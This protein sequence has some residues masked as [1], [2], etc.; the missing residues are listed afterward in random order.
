MLSST[1]PQQ[2]SFLSLCYALLRTASEVQGEITGWRKKWWKEHYLDVQLTFSTR[3]KQ[4]LWNQTDKKELKEK[5]MEY[6]L[7]YHE[8]IEKVQ[9]VHPIAFCIFFSLHS[10]TYST[11]E[12]D[13]KSLKRNQTIENRICCYDAKSSRETSEKE[14][15]K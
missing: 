7:F 10:L 6:H 15:K 11:T 4:H 5:P 1:D 2:Q 13:Y 14:W 8:R 12:Q 3:G 9:H